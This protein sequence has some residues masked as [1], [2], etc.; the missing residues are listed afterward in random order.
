[1]TPDFAVDDNAIGDIG[2]QYLS[3]Q[4]GDM[5]FESAFVYP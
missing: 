1:M 5:V 3:A 4:V 2:Y